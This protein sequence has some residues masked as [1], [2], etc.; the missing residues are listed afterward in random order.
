MR[1]T[2]ENNFNSICKDLLYLY[3]ILYCQL[4]SYYG[5]SLLNRQDNTSQV[6]KN[7]GKFWWKKDGLVLLDP[8]AETLNLS[9]D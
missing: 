1:Y 7:T 3:P 2:F 8:E 5:F 6:R 9:M 4:K